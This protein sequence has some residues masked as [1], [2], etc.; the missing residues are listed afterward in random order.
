MISI[1]SWQAAIETT[2]SYFGDA[3]VAELPLAGLADVAASRSTAY[4]ML[5]DEQAALLEDLVA[6][7]TQPRLTAQGKIEALAAFESEIE[8]SL[9]T[10]RAMPILAAAA[11]GRYSTAY[12]H[13]QKA[14]TSVWNLYPGTGSME[15]LMK[16]IDPTVEADIRGAALGSIGGPK[17]T[18]LGGVI[19]S[20]F[21]ALGRIGDYFGWW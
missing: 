21:S 4:P 5:D 1:L 3:D 13:S 12:W 6:I 17:G 8:H 7:A 16:N 2:Q 9:D 18:V 19:T 15:D 10:E 11:V 20:G 14:E